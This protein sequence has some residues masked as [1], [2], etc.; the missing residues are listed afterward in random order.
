MSLSPWRTL[1][2]FVSSTFR[3]MG[4]ERDGLAKIA[5]P[6]LRERLEPYCIELVDVDLR[7]GITRDEVETGHAL[8]ICLSSVT[9]C[10]P[11]FISLLGEIYGSI[12]QNYDSDA[13]RNYQ[14]LSDY[15]GCSMT[16]LEIILGALLAPGSAQHALFYFRDSA[17]IDMI[18]EPI[19]SARFIET[20]HI[21]RSKLERLKA[22]I[23]QSGAKVFDGYPASWDSEKTDP[24]SLKKGAICGFPELLDRIVDDLFHM[25]KD[26]LH[27]P[28]F[29]TPLN[30]GETDIFIK[31]STLH[32]RFAETACREFVGRE[33]VLKEIETY[34]SGSETR[35][36]ILLGESGQGKT[37][38]MAEIYNRCRQSW[39]GD[40]VI[41]HFVGATGSSFRLSN[42]MTR[43]CEAVRRVGGLTRALPSQAA[44]RNNVFKEVLS[45]LPPER[46]LILLIDGL[47]QMDIAENPH[48]LDWLP[49]PL[50]AQVRIICSSR[51][52]YPLP[53]KLGDGPI[54]RY[55]QRTPIPRLPDVK[56]SAER[57][58]FPILKLSPLS[59]GEVELLLDRI[60]SRY[61]KTL[62]SSQKQH[63]L[64]LSLASNSLFLTVVL[65]ELRLFGSFDYLE[66]FILSLPSPEKYKEDLYDASVSTI[67]LQLVDRL[68]LEYDSALLTQVL[69]FLSVTR[70]GLSEAELE[71][72]IQA[73]QNQSNIPLIL[74][75]LRPYL[76]SRENRHSIRFPAFLTA[77]GFRFSLADFSEEEA[78]AIIDWACGVAQRISNFSMP[79]KGD[80]ERHSELA[81]FFKTLPT[82]ERKATDFY[83]HLSYGTEVDK[84]SL[85][86]QLF[87]DPELLLLAWQM[88]PESVR[89]YSRA[90]ISG[91]QWIDTGRILIQEGLAE[92]ALVNLEDRVHECYERGDLDGVVRLS[93]QEEVV[94]VLGN[95]SEPLHTARTNLMLVYTEQNQHDLCKSVYASHKEYCLSKREERHLVKSLVWEILRCLQG[96][97]LLIAS[98]YAS[99]LWHISDK[100][101]VQLRLKQ[102]AQREQTVQKLSLHLN[103]LGAYMAESKL[104]PAALDCL[105][106]QVRLCTLSGDHPN[107]ANAAYNVGVILFNS[108]KIEESVQA[109]LHSAEMWHAQGDAGRMRGPLQ[110]AVQACLVV[111]QQDLAKMLLE[112][113]YACSQ[114]EPP[115]LKHL[116]EHLRGINDAI[117]K[118][119]Q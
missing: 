43:C 101:A 22:R 24:F 114:A 91:E 16:E 13:L 98:E 86:S 89:A 70:S 95:K 74:R 1:K 107:A 17:V 23:R 34:I 113:W 116:G 53:E 94:A 105:R 71:Q 44:E 117:E 56:A 109:F 90:A 21:S 59:L 35:P 48:E 68:Y 80:Q 29:P 112:C 11:F 64:S 99:E 115:D 78:Q 58:G 63:L 72:L 20:D 3:D 30:Q 31:D 10:Q 88:D 6:A 57:R 66:E 65:E 119:K 118:S 93:R 9:E 104:F 41:P 81:R 14:W 36:L 40:L 82:S 38:L 28:Q 97:H 106:L 79:L 102:M 47:G 92:R 96:K 37:A 103:Q 52:V 46:R 7:W 85:L 84:A 32:V 27:L 111:R 2:V 51:I 49:D 50:P 108:G 60:P 61:A 39:P 26:T 5:F 69:E 67:F 15:Y 83:Y 73:N 33:D 4:A 8:Q 55:D 19:R 110:Q 45:S 12:L 25:I 54:L 75:R 62:N 100:E 77:I 18:P 76:Y 87:E 42:A